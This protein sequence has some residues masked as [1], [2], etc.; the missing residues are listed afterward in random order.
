[1]ADLDAIMAAVAAVPAPEVG[2]RSH[3]PPPERLVAFPVIVVES[4][5]GRWDLGLVEQE[6]ET[7]THEV[8]LSV[9]VGE[10]YA[11][12]R[13]REAVRLLDRVKNRFRSAV[14]LGGLVADCA[15][16]GYSVGR[17]SYA[18]QEYTGGTVTVAVEDKF[19]VDLTP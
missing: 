15:P 11:P 2:G 7:G 18:G 4:A 8:T 14:Q 13:Y 3:Y 5:R 9:F 16:T 6:V 10:G 12:S 17:L 19:P 1:M